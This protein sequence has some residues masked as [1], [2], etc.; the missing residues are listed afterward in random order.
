[1][2]EEIGPKAPVAK[3]VPHQ[4]EIHGS[5]RNDP[6]HW[7]RD[8]TRQD[9]EIRDYLTAEN[10]YT[11]AVLA[12]YS[13]FR[14]NIFK[15][16][17]ARI[18]QDDQ[19][20]P[21]E[22]DGYTY[23]SRQEKGREFTIYCRRQGPQDPEQIIL[24]VNVEAQGHEFY[25]STSPNVT[26]DG[27]TMVFGEDTVGRRVYTLRFRDLT[28]GVDLF[29][30]IEGVTGYGVWAT[31]HQTFFYTRREPKTLR[32]YQV[33]RHRVGM[34]PEDDVLVFQE[35]DEE[36]RLSLSRS[37][38]REFILISS[39]QT[40]SAEYLALNAA[41]PDSTPKVIIPRQRDHECL[42]DHFDGQ[43]FI[44][45]N[46]QA[47]NFRLMSVP[48]EKILDRGAWQVEIPARE[49]V[50]LGGFELFQDFLAVSETQDGLKRVRVLSR[51][52]CD[53][54]D[55]V[56]DEDGYT[57]Y[58]G[59]NPDP[60]SDQLR[61]EYTS[62]T[63]PWSVYEFQVKSGRL[64][65]KKE[66]KVGGDFDRHNY[67][68][69]RMEAIAHDGTPVLISLVW[70]RDLDRS[71][72]QPLL[73]YAY[74]SYGSS[75]NPY[76]SSAR[77]SLLNRGVVFAIA[78]VRG[79][80]EK[81]RRWYD[82]GKLLK[83]RNT[84]TDFITCAEHLVETGWTSKDQ[85]LAQGGS[86]GGLLVGAVINMRGDLFRGV[87]A[88]VPFVDVVT[89]ML[90][91]SIPLTTFEYDEWGNP[92]NKEF[93]DYM[94]SYSPYDNV[95][96]KEYPAMLVLTG[97]HDS[98]VQ[99]WGP[100]KWV[101]KLRATKTDGQALLLAVNMEAGHG[102]SSGRFQ[103]HKETALVYTFLLGLLNKAF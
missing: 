52:V 92:E 56:F 88:D 51:G 55:I 78:H 86:A 79:G 82:D 13:A 4:L 65:L 37:R 77:L 97:L 21:Y 15:E 44:R 8:D 57:S 76:F 16:I 63:T 5:V 64:T 98:Q 48:T 99:Y 27:K 69:Q 33:W 100:V 42:L 30:R 18:P 62:L 102:G 40:L 81:G 70:R 75:I 35:D 95:G 2:R 12:P 45:T 25:S 7:L 22:K 50:L 60:G 68:T 11:E 19:S 94:L 54:H 39:D 43:F 61:L 20:V 71:V 101:A 14:E 53:V 73:L 85:L 24:D 87:V 36:F 84:F 91:R 3:V 26:V 59:Y 32:A 47:D 28:T 90:D 46:W 80:Q 41:R 83:K 31:D 17:V 10:D 66:S 23:Y 96:A 34:D 1:M 67:Q 58:L 74:G 49:D 93:Y 38:S 29:D 6:Y 9:P 103:Q 72:P 89:T